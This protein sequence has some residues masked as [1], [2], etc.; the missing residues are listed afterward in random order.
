[1][2]AN[3]SGFSIPPATP[4][5]VVKAMDCNAN[6]A[7]FAMTLALLRSANGTQHAVSAGEPAADQLSAEAKALAVLAD[8]PDWTNTAIAEAAGVVRTSLYRFPRFMQAREVQERERLEKPRGSKGK[9]GT[10][11]AF[12]E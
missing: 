1:M 6:N 11:E 5:D 12:D 4:E 7:A 8:H 9:D 10:I 3:N 2:N